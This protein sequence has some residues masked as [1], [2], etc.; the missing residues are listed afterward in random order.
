MPIEENNS[1]TFS[2]RYHGLTLF[3]SVVLSVVLHFG[4]MYYW[5]GAQLKSEAVEE[6]KRAH[7]TPENLPPVKIDT[8]LQAT[9]LIQQQVHAEAEEAPSVEEAA[10]SA[11]ET[12]PAKAE[13]T[14][15]PVPT[16][17]LIPSPEVATIGP[18]DVPVPE[19]PAVEIPKLSVRQEVVAVP[20]NPFTQTTNP[21]PQWTIDDRVVRI[22]DAPDLASSTLASDAKDDAFPIALPAFGTGADLAGMLESKPSIAEA[23]IIAEPVAVAS[24]VTETPP[25]LPTVTPAAA[26][27]LIAPR[28]FQ[29]IDD[30]L[31]LTLNT[32]TTAADPK[33]LYYRLS[34]HRRPEGKLPILPKDVVFIQDISGSIGGR[35]L[36][37]CKETLKA[38][39]FNT[40]RAGDRFNIFAFRD[41]TLAPARGWISFNPDT[42][43][44][45][46]T[47]ID[48]L[49]ARGNTDLFLLLQDLRTLPTDPTRPLIAIIVTD[50]DPTVGVTETTRIIGEFTRLNA[51]NISVYTFG[52]KRNDPYFLDMLTYANRGE[53]TASDGSIAKLPYDLTP[54]F[55]SIRNPVLKNPTLT[56]DTKSS[57]DVH[58]KYI[59]HLYA[60]R[61]LTVYGRVPRTT[62]KIT[63]QLRGE[64]VASPYDAIFT[65]N[66]A[67]ARK[68]QDNLRKAWAERAMFDMLSEYAS[69]PSPQL[70]HKISTFSSLYNVPN[71]YRR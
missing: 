68:T 10:E 5:R 13:A 64:A 3:V 35:R 56:F 54:V 66:L 40:L 1:E 65:F 25:P 12:L 51:G 50:G 67:T 7:I 23:A 28:E 15:V 19:T 47:F 29:P 39:L 46:E 2:L 4:A 58:P 37:A 24:S 22:P 49:R 8:L 33:Y 31:S 9:D 34:I 57:T 26:D 62:S 42:R 32:F 36:G 70:L 69:N 53:N 27:A 11:A 61:P 52:V 60:D 14:A 18:N 16:L 20:D 38:A 63:C 48:S 6:V 45:A 59:T 71:P 55:E 43:E 41:K 21:D 30:R 44:R 17:P